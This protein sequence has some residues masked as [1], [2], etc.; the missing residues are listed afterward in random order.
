MANILVATLGDHPA[1]VTGMVKMLKAQKGITLDEIAVFHTEGSGKLISLGYDL[2]EAA[3]KDQYL[4]VQHKLPFADPTSREQSIEFLRSL[5]NVLNGYD[6]R[7]DTVYL[8]L[9]GG[10]KNMSALMAVICQFYPSVKG[11]FHLITHSDSAFPPIEEVFD[12][13]EEK[14][15]LAMHP[16][17]EEMTLVEIPYHTL[18]NA[19]ELRRYFAAEDRG[20]NYLIGLLPTGEQFLREVFQ[21][22]QPS[23]LLP[24][25][26]TET[27]WVEVQKLVADGGKRAKNFMTCFEQM[28]D[29]VRLKG[30]LHASRDKFAFYKR[31][32][33]VERPFFHT[34]PNPINL[35]PN[36]PVKKVII[37]GLSIEQDDG[38]YKPTMETL[39][40][41]H[42]LTPAHAFAE[43]YQKPLILVVPLGESPMVASQTYTLLQQADREWEK[44]KV[45][46]V[47]VLY[48][49]QNGPIRDGAKLLEKAFKRR[50]LAFEKIPI[51]GLRD[52]DSFENAQI[53]RDTVIKTINNL[54]RNHPDKQIALSLSGG[55]KGMSALTL[56]AA[57]VAGV[58]QVYHTT[59]TDPDYEQMVLRET[60][61]DKLPSNRD[62]LAKT[63]FLDKYDLS[64]FTLFEI[65]VISLEPPQ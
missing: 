51:T 17:E 13:P 15:R 58:S 21:P 27:V 63:L 20:D 65:P 22:N 18:S 56:F 61:L 54:R 3:L 37:C 60:R 53:Y 32:R 5:N 16:P 30:G 64:N 40:N 29:P 45:V 26:F 52:V 4:V 28:Q 6:Q 31:R 11:L 44:Q 10:R 12:M 47:V 38:S 57:Q 62:E 2:V 46:K 1:V 33:T 25:Y 55:R 35:F 23:E 50:G 34:E 42:D 9:A 59:I 36:K 19:V 49:E 14:R 43:L 24:L 41:R 8:S 48:P 7:G 39:L